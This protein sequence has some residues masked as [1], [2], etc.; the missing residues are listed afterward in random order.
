MCVSAVIIATSI[1]H[2]CKLQTDSLLSSGSNSDKRLITFQTKMPQNT[3]E[4]V[5]LMR[6]AFNDRKLSISGRCTVHFSAVTN[7]YFPIFS[8]LFDWLFGVQ[9]ILEN[10]E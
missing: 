4:S 8:L 2:I 3:T 7:N 1:H 9:K 5:C 6:R 10:G